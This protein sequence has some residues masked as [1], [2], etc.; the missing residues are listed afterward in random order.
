MSLAS[1]L[2]TAMVGLGL[3]WFFWPFGGSDEVVKII[4]PPSAHDGRLFTTPLPEAPSPEAPL[5]KAAPPKPA[6]AKAP[7]PQTADPPK[8][9]AALPATQP[10]PAKD[11]KTVAAVSP[12]GGP[13]PVDAATPKTVLKPK[14]FYRVVVR[15]GGTLKAGDVVITLDGIKAHAADATCKDAKGRVWACG[16]QARIALMRLIRGR[17]VS[18][19]VPASSTAKTLTARCSVAG[20][21]LSEWLVRYGWVKPNAPADT[22]LAKAADTARKKKI[23]VWR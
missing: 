5:P 15:D 14:R 1:R 8:T 6:P 18:C 19:K 13:V 7:P 17:A 11:G 20:T 2:I 4:E 3:I 23:G 10:A 12:E 16:K 9:T 22:K 21:G